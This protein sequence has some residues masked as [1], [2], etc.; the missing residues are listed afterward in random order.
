[1][2]RRSGMTLMEV[3]IA[4]FVMG[5]GLLA[6][7]AMFPL[8]ASS[9]ARAIKDDRAGHAAANAKALAIALNVRFDSY[10]TSQFNTAYPLD[11]PSNPVLVD[12]L[13]Y[14]SYSPSSG[15]QNAVA[16]I[17]GRPGPGGQPLLPRTTV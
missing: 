6:V 11:G 1:M 8:G 17:A 15:T 4:I 14:M 5:I 7:M 3:L 16:P 13:G 12:P 2:N 10:V 9:M